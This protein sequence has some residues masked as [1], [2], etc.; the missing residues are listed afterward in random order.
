MGGFA[1]TAQA[2][3]FTVTGTEVTVGYD[4]PT[5]NTDNSALTDLDHTT[6]YYDKGAGPVAEATVP[7][8]AP[9]G[10]GT[11]T[12]TI[13]VPVLAGE[14]ADVNFWV[15]AS[16]QSGNESVPSPVITQRIDRLSPKAPD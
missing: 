12:T 1:T 8:T 7:A 9:T 6:I 2:I 4:E 16:D 10:G 15:T 13:T 3:T 5:Q 11:I 14:E